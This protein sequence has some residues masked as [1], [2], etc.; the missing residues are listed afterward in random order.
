MVERGVSGP[1]EAEQVIVDGTGMASASSILQTMSE[2]GW[3]AR[4][5]PAERRFDL[6]KELEQRLS[7]G[8]FDETFFEERLRPFQESI[9]KAPSWAR[10]ILIVA[11]P[12]PALTVRFRWKG[13]EVGLRIPP[14][15]VRWEERGELYVRSVLAK[16]AGE[17]GLQAETAS[18]P[19]KLLATR[20]GMARYGRNNLTYVEGMGSYYRLCSL[21]TDVPCGENTWQEAE[22]LESCASCGACIRACPTGTID[23][24]RYLARAERCITYWQEKSGDVPYPEEFDFSWQDQFIGCTRCQAACP[25]NRDLLKVEEAG[26][27]FT[28]EETA[29]FLRGVTAEKLPE[30]TLEKLKRHDVL[31]Y[32]E[33]LPRNL[34]ASLENASRDGTELNS[35]PV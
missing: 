14:T 1:D 18:L 12:D 11:I 15:F 8:E 7:R 22:V 27:A 16:L 2:R 20:S 19:K 4:L 13:R 21:Y 29:S 31:D 25:Y 3:A 26:P 35:D 10:S 23:P 28:E 33:V 6:W 24:D 34:R 32:L 9:E 17:G 30:E 5:V